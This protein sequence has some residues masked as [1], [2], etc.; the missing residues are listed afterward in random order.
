MLLGGGSASS[1]CDVG[2]CA[3]S[4]SRFDDGTRLCPRHPSPV[5]PLRL[6]SHHTQSHTRT[7]ERITIANNENS[8][9]R[10][11]MTNETRAEQHYYLPLAHA[12]L[13]SR[14]R[15]ST[16]Q[17]DS[18]AAA[19]L[20]HTLTHMCGGSCF[21]WELRSRV[22]SNALACLSGNIIFANKYAHVQR[23][24]PPPLPTQMPSYHHI[25]A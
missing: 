3:T 21:F 17:T 6:I 9:I 18:P 4:V 25:R 13:S 11:E 22:S 5:L 2:P 12:Q 14:V 24:M 20:S 10:R 8:R 1:Y 23:D 16:K 19:V 15:V 7:H